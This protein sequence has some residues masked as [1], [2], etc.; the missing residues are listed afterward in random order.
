[1][2]LT[3]CGPV[4]GMTQEEILSSNA[5]WQLAMD[6]TFDKIGFP[7]V[8]I[9]TCAGDVVFVMGL[10]ARLPGRDL[11]KN[12]QYQFIEKPNMMHD[13]YRFIV[14]NGWNAFYNPYLMRIQRPQIEITSA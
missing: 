9:S 2:I 14:K 12:A 11:D 5:K 3:W 7:D 6:R 10:P 1:M 13:D 4:A 8:F